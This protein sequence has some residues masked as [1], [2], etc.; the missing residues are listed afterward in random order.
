MKKVFI[1]IISVFVLSSFSGCALN[2]V[3]K[4]ENI[5]AG[6]TL[7]FSG[8]DLNGN[9]IT[10]DLFKGYNLI[11]INKWGTFCNPCVQEMPDIQK[12][13][14]EFKNKKVK[15]IGV[16]SID[17]EKIDEKSLINDAKKIISIKKIN[18]L[19]ILPDKKLNEQLNKFDFVPVT[20]FIKPNG[21]VLETYITGATK[22]DYFKK[23][24]NSALKDELK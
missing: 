22:F 14:D 5:L 2:K 20:L 3:E 16:I 1:I 7:N 9:K 4:E 18:Y 17:K 10:K 15:V 19:N 6:K 8:K 12:I 21:E 24:I 11:M 13:Q 23:I